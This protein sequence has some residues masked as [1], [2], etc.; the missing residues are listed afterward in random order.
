[1]SPRTRGYRKARFEREMRVSTEVSREE[2]RT[3]PESH[4]FLILREQTNG[5]VRKVSHRWAAEL[6]EQ[7]KATEE[8]TK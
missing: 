2:T 1:M 7:C 5:R 6:T 8:L 4:P 3:W